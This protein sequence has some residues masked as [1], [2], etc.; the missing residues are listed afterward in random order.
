M[1]EIKALPCNLQVFIHHH[2]VT[3]IM[4]RANTLQLVQLQ[5]ISNPEQHH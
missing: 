1:I 4:T 2:V 5:E 3:N